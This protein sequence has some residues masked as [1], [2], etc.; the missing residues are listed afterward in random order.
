[1]R[2][3]GRVLS[4]DTRRSELLIISFL[5]WALGRILELA[6][7]LFRRE[8]AKEVEILERAKSCVLSTFGPATFRWLKPAANSSNSV[9]PKS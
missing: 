5:Y 6:V 1:M 7:L 2:R 4:D 9:R 8:E 3:V